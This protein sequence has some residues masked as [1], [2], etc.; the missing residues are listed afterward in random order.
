[1]KNTHVQ[2]ELIEESFDSIPWLCVISLC[3][4]VLLMSIFFLVMHFLLY[5]MYVISWLN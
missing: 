1:M 5:A 3:I 4:D 2:I